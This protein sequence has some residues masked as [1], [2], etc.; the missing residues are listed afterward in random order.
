VKN[1][2]PGEL[3]GTKDLR[4]LETP[5]LGGT[6]GDLLARMILDADIAGNAFV[7]RRVGMLQRLRPDWV[8]LVYGS[9]SDPNVDAWDLD[10]EL[11]GYLY[12]P[13]GPSEG[14]DYETI[15]PEQ[16]AHFAP[17]P[18]PLSPYRGMSWLTPLIREISADSGMT[19]HKLA[20]VEN[21]A[22]PNMIVKFV[23]LPGI[24]PMTTDAFNKWVDTFEANHAG[25][26]NAYKTIYLG[27][28]A[29]ATV[30]GA[31]LQQME[32]SATQGAGEVRICA[33]AGVHPAIVGTSE[34]LKGSSLN[35]GNFG[36]ARRL[37]ADVTA[38]PLW[39][40]AAGSLAQIITVPQGSELWY[41]ESDVSFLQ[42]DQKDAAEIEQIQAI[43]IRQLL[44]AGYKAD[45]VIGAIMAKDMGRLVGQHTGLFSVQL[46]APGSTKMPEGEVAGETPVGPGTAPEKA[47]NGKAPTP[48]G[49][50]P[51]KPPAG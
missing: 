44:E 19:T 12:Q 40:N 43:A 41:D 48:A 24:P 37:F 49:A 22:T 20:F 34:G 35:A 7:T 45:A 1:G 9:R 2:K 4:L 11:I 51:A 46:Q 21:A 18:D 47:G 6:T 13:G 10:A 23:P 36:A 30:V 50:F 33:A 42:E 26:I 17:M 8:T 38:R 5:W 29:D 3:F 39:R 15:L 27:G 25:A 31:N 28:G 14:K 16:M 32:F